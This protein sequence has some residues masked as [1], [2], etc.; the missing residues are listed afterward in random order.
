MEWFREDIMEWS[1]VFEVHNQATRELRGSK[2][3]WDIHT[4]R[5]GEE[6]CFPA[7]FLPFFQRW[8]LV[9]GWSAR[10]SKAAGEAGKGG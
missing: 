2:R 4:F 8:M 10:E 5:P 9:G 1:R 3:P 7:S 6:R